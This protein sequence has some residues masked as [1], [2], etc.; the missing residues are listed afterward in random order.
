MTKFKKEFLSFYTR[1][2]GEDAKPSDYIVLS[3]FL[4]GIY[5]FW[6]TGY[7]DYENLYGKPFKLLTEDRQWNQTSPINYFIG[8]FFS[9]ILKPKISYFI[10]HFIN[11]FS[12]VLALKYFTKKYSEINFKSLISMLFLTPIIYI[13][14]IWAGKT[15]G[16]LVASIIGVASSKNNNQLFSWSLVGVFSHPEGFFI[17]IFGLLLFNI[18]SPRKFCKILLSYIIYSIY[19]FQI[20]PFKNRYDYLLIWFEESKRNFEEYPI[21]NFISFFGFFWF[22]LYA[23]RD[24]IKKIHKEYFLFILI[25]TLLTADSTRIFALLSLPLIISFSISNKFSL[26]YFDL[27]KKFKIFSSF[28][29]LSLFHFQIASSKLT[30]SSPHNFYN[31]IG[32]LIKKIYNYFLM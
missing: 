2:G 19:Y 24:Y 7:S 5:G 3:I 28:F 17:Q 10:I 15:N 18:I 1:V 27:L 29:F 23:L 14:F 30:F 6:I 26:S 32:P 31:Y 25:I 13:V 9:F 8:Y 20:G 16:F 11:I 12:I 4:L 22:F 21:L